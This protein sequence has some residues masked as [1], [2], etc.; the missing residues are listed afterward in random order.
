MLPAE[1][2]VFIAGGIGVTPYRA[3]LVQLDHDQTAF[4]A[5]MLYANRDENYPFKD[6]FEAVASRRDG[7]ELSYFTDPEHIGLNDIQAAAA[8]YANPLYYISG[9]EPMVE[10]YKVLLINSGVAEED[11]ATDYFPGYESL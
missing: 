4:Q 8:R 3:M 10:S 2:S 9:P 6:E 5:T 7:F 11:I 1:T